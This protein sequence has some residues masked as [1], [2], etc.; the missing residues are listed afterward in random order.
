MLDGGVGAAA[1]EAQQDTFI[2]AGVV[3]FCDERVEFNRL[4]NDIDADFFQIRFDEHS[5]FLPCAVADVCVQHEFNLVSVGIGQKIVAV[6]LLNP[7]FL[8][9]R[10]R[11]GRSCADTF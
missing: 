4:E 5:R 9:Q 6:P 3:N 10:E 8:Q 1:A 7:D 11:F 2:I